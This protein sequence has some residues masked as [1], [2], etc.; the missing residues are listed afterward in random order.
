MPLRVNDLRAP[1]GARRSRTRV[2]R[3]DGSGRGTY[4]GRGLKG[5]KSRAGGG[6]RPGFEGGQFGLIRKMP[7]KRGFHPL[8]RVE[9]T[10]VNV[11]QLNDRFEAGAEI[12]AAALAA[13]GLLRDAEEP[14][15]VLAR[16]DLERAFTIRAP[17][18]SAA[19]RSKIEAAGGTIEAAGPRV[20]PAPDTDTPPD[21]DTRPDTDTPPDTDAAAEPSGDDD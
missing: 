4:S 10:A 3:G 1:A 20:R 5:Q 2:G 18:V 8:F 9:F 15:K 17:R 13:A 11:G 14:F 6:K 21:T 19:A 7:R 12:D 16:G